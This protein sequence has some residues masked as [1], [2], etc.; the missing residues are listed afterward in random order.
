VK[1]FFV[2][3]EQVANFGNRLV[4]MTGLEPATSWSQTRRSSLLSYIPR[5]RENVAW[6][7]EKIKL[8]TH[9]MFLVDLVR[10]NYMQ[11]KILIIENDPFMLKLYQ[12]YLK[13]YPVDFDF[14][15]DGRQ[16]LEQVQEYQPSLLVMDMEMPNMNGLEALSILSQKGVSIPVVIVSNYEN[17][18]WI[19]KSL[20]LG[21]K[22]YLIKSSYTPEALMEK[23][24]SFLDLPK[25]S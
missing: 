4:G 8:M 14:A 17:P 3:T 12:E 25:A 5:T 2:A 16:G 11:K 1:R 20:A 10:Y 24:T 22:A 19:E 6:V 9:W 21:A 7:C 13:R 15:T 18:E 23:I